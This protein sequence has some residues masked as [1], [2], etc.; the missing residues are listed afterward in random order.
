MMTNVTFK[1]KVCLKWKI[2][3]SL[4]F[5][6]IKYKNSQEIYINFIKSNLLS[7][8]GWG[9]HKCHMFFPNII[10]SCVSVST[11]TFKIYLIL[12][13]PHQFLHVS[14]HSNMWFLLSRYIFV[15]LLTWSMCVWWCESLS[16]WENL[17]SMRV[18]MQYNIYGIYSVIIMKI[19]L[20]LC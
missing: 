8:T 12:G 20:G 9:R 15:M 10:G 19:M 1:S 3:T 6:D 7:K 14:N 5:Y 16:S 2:L 13:C 11:Q 17:S 4:R 18:A